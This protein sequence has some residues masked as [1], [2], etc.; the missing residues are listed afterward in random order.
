MSNIN[1]TSGY[2]NNQEAEGSLEWHAWGEGYD[3]ATRVNGVYENP[4]SGGWADQISEAKAVYSAWVHLAIGD[5]WIEY[6]QQ[7]LVG[8]VSDEDYDDAL[9]AFE[10]GYNAWR[11][12]N[13]KLS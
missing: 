4:L 13:G 11:E 1:G 3:Y 8:I 12:D 9:D 7:R 6:L 5:S 2:Y 10:T